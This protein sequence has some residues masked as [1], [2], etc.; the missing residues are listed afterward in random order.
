[1][2]QRLAARVTHHPNTQLRW[3]CRPKRSPCPCGAK[4]IAFA[5]D[6]YKKE[7]N[8]GYDDI[9]YLLSQNAIT[10]HEEARTWSI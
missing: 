5:I 10:T 3:I 4:S 2:L 6:P 1:V 7:Y 9:D 8:N